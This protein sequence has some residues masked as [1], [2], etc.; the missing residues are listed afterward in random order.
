MNY[1]IKIKVNQIKILM[2]Y[3]LMAYIK[4]TS[5]GISCV[6]D[7]RREQFSK[8]IKKCIECL[9]WLVVLF[10]RFYLILYQKI[11]IPFFGSG[12]E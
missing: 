7:I 2:E 3:R 6:K 5:H 9:R 11:C 8:Q 12:F 10:N 1:T 4:K